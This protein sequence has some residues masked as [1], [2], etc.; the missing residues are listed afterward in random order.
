MFLVYP[1]L[2]PIWTLKTG[3]LFLFTVSMKDLFLN[4][5]LICILRDF[6][7][8][9]A[10]EVLGG[11]KITA[12]QIYEA[13]G[14]RVEFKLGPAGGKTEEVPGYMAI[15]CRRASEHDIQFMEDWKRT[16]QLAIIGMKPKTIKIAEGIT[17]VSNLRSIITKR[18]R[19]AKDGSNAGKKQVSAE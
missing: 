7:N 8:V 13:K 14:E 6:D 16:N 1:R 4:D 10:D 18:T 17:G 5:G 15:R 2:D 19:I 9:G 12:K 11:I 3:S